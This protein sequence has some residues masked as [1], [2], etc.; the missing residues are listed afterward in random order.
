MIHQTKVTVSGK[1]WLFKN[2]F[3]QSNSEP[4][5]DDFSGSLTEFEPTVWTEVTED[6][7]H[8]WSSLSSQ[9]WALQV[10]TCPS[11]P[12]SD[13]GRHPCMAAYK[14]QQLHSCFHFPHFLACSA[15]KFHLK[16]SSAAQG[17]KKQWRPLLQAQY[18]VSTS[19]C[20]LFRWQS[21][22]RRHSS[23]LDSM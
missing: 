14:H 2:F 16:Q 9:K 19:S 3:L 17:H 21:R 12:S 15:F 7:K 18:C 23:A 6:L 11:V 13:A 10:P 20:I 1:K 4:L 5:D 8:S 22:N